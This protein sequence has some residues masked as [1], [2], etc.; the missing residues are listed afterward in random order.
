M[1]TTRENEMS[2]RYLRLLQRWIPFGMSCYSDWPGRPDC[3]Y[4]FGGVL[5]YGHDTSMPLF[6]LAVAAASEEYDESITGV[7]RDELMQ[8]AR[9]GLR[10]LC[11]THDTGPEDCVRPTESWGRTEPA[12]TKWGERGRGFFPES[13]CGTTIANLALAAR[14]LD[15]V[16]G[17]EEHEM[18][19]AIA[20]DYMER[21]E[22]MEP[23][24]GVYQDTQTEENAWTALGMAACIALAPDYPH[25]DYWLS[26]MECWAFR[27]VTTPRDAA[28]QRPFAEGMS[29][30]EWCGGTITTLPDGTAENHG[31][32]H[33]TYMASSIGMAAGTAMLLALHGQEVPPHLAWRRRKTYDI[34]KSWT[35]DTGACHCPQ[36]MD[37][38]YLLHTICVMT[39]ASANLFLHD[40]D[41][42]L[43]E[44][45]CLEVLETVSEIHGGR[46]IPERTVRHCCGQQDTA[47]MWERMIASPALACLYHRFAGSGERPSD[48]DEFRDRMNGVRLY[49][50]GSVLLHHHAKGINS[51]SWR[52]RT[53]ALPATRDGLKH[54]GPAF[55]SLLADVS[56]RDKTSLVDEVLCRCRDS[57]DRAC[58]LLIQELAERTIQRLVFFASLPDG[59]CLTHERLTSLSDITIECMRQGYLAVMNDPYFNTTLPDNASLTIH[60]PGGPETFEG[61]AAPDES[62]DRDIELPGGWINVDGRF[63]IVYDGGGRA[64]YRNRHHYDP[65]HAIKDD[66]VLNLGEEPR[67]VAAGDDIGTLT[68]LWLPHQSPEETKNTSLAVQCDGPLFVAE[69]EGFVCACNFGD[70]PQGLPGRDIT[71]PPH[72]PVLV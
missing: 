25:M 17:D 37:W 64:V 32:V 15:D 67:D 31:I 8:V 68:V 11:F 24:A 66:L 12:G 36:G 59:R 43:L 57:D 4:F 62:Q 6:A 18:L 34:L 46:L 47:V 7:P 50:Q 70:V 13:Q 3:G 38:P 22:L 51:F 60:T 9:R 53:M 54:V 45:R 39:H 58:A 21:F 27:A 61:F 49:S 69:V 65:W 56:V 14:L 28:D 10:Y 44:R 19:R 55:H 26:R 30:A 5:W 29:V 16:L 52:N 42:A 63:G 40:P 71:I 41:G 35:D 33:P 23:R 48:P 2:R 20:M 72:E 1:N